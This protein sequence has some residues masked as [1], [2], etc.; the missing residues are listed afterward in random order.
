MPQRHTPS[1][2]YLCSWYKSFIRE[3]QGNKNIVKEG[4]FYLDVIRMFLVRH[5]LYCVNTFPICVWN[6]CG[7]LHL[8]LIFCI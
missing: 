5:L 2:E 1:V 4:L 6:I 7:H 8:R 3:Q